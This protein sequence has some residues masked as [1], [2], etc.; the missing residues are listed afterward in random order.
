MKI[1][2]F[3]LLALIIWGT[4]ELATAATFYERMRDETLQEM[5]LD[6]NLKPSVE[7]IV[8]EFVTKV[9]SPADPKISAGGVD[10]ALQRK[11]NAFCTNK[12]TG[13]PM[14]IGF[15]TSYVDRIR[16]YAGAEERIR[17]LGRDLQLIA[18]SYELPI[19]GY[20]GRVTTLPSRYKS[21]VNLWRAGH[22]ESADQDGTFR[23]QP[24]PN[25]KDT[26]WKDLVKKLEESLDKLS[27]EERTAAVWRYQHGARFVAEERK[28]YP[29]PLKADTASL[30]GTERQYLFKRWDGKNK[31]ENLEK[32]L[33][34]LWNRLKT[35][36]KNFQPP[37][38]IGDIVF[39]PE[40]KLGDI[41]GWVF[42]EVLP[43]ISW[44]GAPVISGDAGLQWKNPMEPVLPAL[45]SDK[46]PGIALFGGA[47][48][49]EL[50][51]GAGLCTFPFAKL[52]YLCRPIEQAAGIECDEE[53]GVKKTPGTITLTRCRTGTERMT[54]SGPNIC[55]DVLWQTP[56]QGA[57]EQKQTASCAECKVI[58]ECKAACGPKDGTVP[59]K[60]AKGEIKICTTGT[61]AL[62]PLYSM[63]H[64]LVLSQRL[65][66][67]PAGTALYGK[68]DTAACCMVEK[69]AFAVAC[70]AVQKDG[71]F[72][73][74]K[75]SILPEI[76]LQDCVDYFAN[77]ACAKGTNAICTTKPV[78]PLRQKQIVDA[79]GKAKLKSL[80][81]Q[82]LTDPT[83]S[84]DPRLQGLR[85]GLKN[86]CNPE[87]QTKYANTIGNSM[88]Y[89]G[90]C[91]EQSFEEH[92]LMPGRTA[93]T[94]QDEAFPWDSCAAADPAFASFMTPPPVTGTSFPSYRPG[95]I[96]QKID[97]AL[98]QVNGLPPQSAAI[99]CETNALRRLEVP[100]ET[101]LEN[102][103][104]LI[105]Q[106]IE[107]RHPA[108]QIK[109]LAP[110]LGTRVGT[111]LYVNYL[112]VAG[113][114]LGEITAIAAELLGNLTEIKFPTE[115]CPRDGAGSKALKA[116]QLCAAIGATSA[117][118]SG[119]TSPAPSP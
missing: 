81:C 82:A 83:K 45:F 1:R 35:D 44:G 85:D 102:T 54:D 88:C 31:T 69:D 64:D 114:A 24:L 109:R 19:D 112:R 60:D 27:K 9:V 113:R 7:D 55:R 25:D 22:Q 52:G 17:T 5:L 103:M 42:L 93:F 2:I 39:Y 20:P 23:A 98:C 115:L 62:P 4:P 40:I 29:L 15:C 108:E 80:S 28:E 71:L 74:T 46:S 92:R 116:H 107:R 37:L 86:I 59:V 53:P 12:T 90:Q 11:W 117:K 105:N 21:L 95:W 14:D 96:I 26:L 6:R 106:I 67:A 65:C 111:T 13:E 97:T 51:D 38:V 73:N 77:A 78:N 18:A 48:P 16:V 33:K 63:M 70:E 100:L 36:A 41:T 3:L 68:T 47:Y 72:D 32:A 89:I 91:I 75:T 34:E 76:S 94:V 61:R 79:L 87:C 104:H 84:P 119:T 30:P 10:L 99:L 110:G 118:P 56:P 58:F 66:G 8:A 57:E 50:R 43:P 49:P 101:S